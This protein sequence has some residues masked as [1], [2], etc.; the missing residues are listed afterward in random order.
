MNINVMYH[1]CKVLENLEKWTLNMFEK[2]Q[3]PWL[4]LEAKIVTENK[5]CLNVQP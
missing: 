1:R 5:M 4:S 3:E 2:V